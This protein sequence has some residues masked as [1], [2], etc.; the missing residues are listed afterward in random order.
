MPNNLGYQQDRI[1]TADTTEYSCTIVLSSCAGTGQTS[2]HNI[3]C[4]SQGGSQQHTESRSCKCNIPQ[5]QTLCKERTPYHTPKSGSSNPGLK[6]ITH[7]HQHLCHKLLWAVHSNHKPEYTL[8][9]PGNGHSWGLQLPGSYHSTFHTKCQFNI[10][11]SG[12]LQPIRYRPYAKNSSTYSR[13]WP[14][15]LPSTLPP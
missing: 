1:K 14:S 15:H 6:F 4:H 7:R 8:L 13:L 11:H 9:Q 5:T 2:C 10:N 3:K 12:H